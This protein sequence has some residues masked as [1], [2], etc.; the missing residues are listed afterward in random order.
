MQPLRRD[1]TVGYFVQRSDDN[2]SFFA[3]ARYVQEKFGYYP[4]IPTVQQ[5]QLDG[6]P[7]VPRRSDGNEHALNNGS[8]IGFA[9]PDDT[10]VLL[11]PAAQ[12]PAAAVTEDDSEEYELGAPFPKSA[13]SDEYWEQ[14]EKWVK[15]IQDASNTK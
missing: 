7:R 6:M 4:Y 3:L 11:G 13:Y 5:F 8:I 10:G 12:C 14:Y 9:T 2:L 1:T 15:E